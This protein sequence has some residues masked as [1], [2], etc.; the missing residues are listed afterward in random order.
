MNQNNVRVDK[1]DLSILEPQKK[2]SISLDKSKIHAGAY[3]VN[4]LVLSKSDGH[5]TKGAY[6]FSLSNIGSRNISS[7]QSPMSNQSSSS[8]TQAFTKGFINN[9]VNLTMGINPL[10][11]GNNTFNLAVTGIDGKPVK[12]I[13]NIYLIFNN[14]GKDLGPIVETMNKVSDGKY[15]SRG[16]FISELGSWE[17]KIIVQRMGEYD[18]NQIFNVNVT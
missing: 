15:T 12:N 1:N 11:V 13:N 5:I 7:Q 17:I 6:V 14:P 10:K 4:W 3:T 8:T 9:N 2:L 16:S 18:I